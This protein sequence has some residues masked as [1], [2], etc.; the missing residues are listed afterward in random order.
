VLLE[1]RGAV[2]TGHPS[3]EAFDELVA[4]YHADSFDRAAA[5]APGRDG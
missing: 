4:S 3:D 1:R 5:A 2:A